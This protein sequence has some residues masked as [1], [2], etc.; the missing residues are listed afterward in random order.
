[1][2]NKILEWRTKEF[3][4]YDRTP[5]WYLTMGIIV[6]LLIAYEAYGRDWF[7]AISLLIIAGIVYFF[8]RL[9]PKDVGVVITDKAIE[10]DRAR[11]TYPNIKNF[12]ISDFKGLLSL[13]FE[14]TA[15]LNRFITI[16][17]NDQN[18]EEVRQV[19]KAYLPEIEEKD[20]G[21]ARRISRH[22][23]F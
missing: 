20:E 15:Y 16:L 8:A 17:L 22:L 9:T 14:T 21:I 7:G 1:M 4:N 19:L 23:K 2:E 11:F 12:W 13:H 6:L 3:E 10:V 18:P 5:G